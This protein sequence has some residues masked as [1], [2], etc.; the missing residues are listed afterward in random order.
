M[1]LLTMI[2]ISDLHLGR[3]GKSGF[4][5]RAPKLWAKWKYFDGLLGHSYLSLVRLE[6]LFSKLRAE[7]NAVLVITGDLTTVGNSDEYATARDYLGNVLKPPKGNYLG[8]KYAQWNELCIPGNHD[9]WP[10]APVIIG[11]INGDL[12]KTFGSLPQQ[13]V[14]TLPSGYKLRFLRIDSDADI[15]PY[16]SNRIM[17]R[18]S[19]KSQLEKLG[20]MLGVPETNEIRVL[21]LH[22]SYIATG[23]ILVINT[24]SKAALHDFILEHDVCALLCGHVHQ[25][26]LVEVRK[27]SRLKQT[28]HFLD[29]RC[30]TTSQRSTVPY[31]W[32]TVLGKRPA[33]EDHWPNSL[34]VHRL[35]QEG[36]DLS[37]G[38]EIYLERSDG[39]F[40]ADQV[41]SRPVAKIQLTMLP[42]DKR[43][44]ATP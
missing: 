15:S 31:E 18:G 37:W 41:L 29:G 32:T 17:A 10:G 9:H 3:I 2:H 20:S 26:P 28:T 11:P 13:A 22:H 39:F 34:L 27:V 4:D 30:G 12:S 5:A 24:A 42:R 8:L 6:Q 38:T 23:K 19:F 43:T 35:S 16:G 33:E 14:I 1:R 36:G 44:A 7:E 40:P 25:P 21:L